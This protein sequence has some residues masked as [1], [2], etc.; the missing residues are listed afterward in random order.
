[1]NETDRH[2]LV[3]DLHLGHANILRH[4]KRP[5]DN[6]DHHDVCLRAQC[7]S[8]LR[9]GVTLWL[10]GDV[11]TNKKDLEAF[12]FVARPRGGRIILIR[13]NHDDKAAWTYRDQFDEAYEARYV[14]V[15]KDVKMYL[16]HYAHRVWRNSHHGS[17]HF[18]GHSHGAL[19][20]LGRSMDV[21]APCVGYK[22]ICLTECVRQL[23][24]QPVTYQHHADT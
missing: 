8:V 10:L 22:P 16:S 21:G 24:D 17:Y 5:F 13:G 11:A 2:W 20:R 19:P 15:D 4:D 23:Q 12:M 18:H 6:I 7:A 9:P 14:R 3:A 1:M